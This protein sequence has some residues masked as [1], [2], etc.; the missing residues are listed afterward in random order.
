MTDGNKR[1]LVYRC[2]DLPA[3]QAGGLVSKL[4]ARCRSWIKQIHTSF[5]PRVARLAAKPRARQGG[6]V[7]TT[8]IYTSIHNIKRES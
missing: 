6:Q 3:L 1:K 4:G 7:S 8:S 2:G 5:L